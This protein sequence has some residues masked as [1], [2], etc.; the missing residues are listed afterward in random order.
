VRGALSQQEVVEATREE[1]ER[2]A[3]ERQGWTPSAGGLAW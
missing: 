3:E 2:E 1:R